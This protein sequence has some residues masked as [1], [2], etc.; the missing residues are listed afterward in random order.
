MTRLR[1]PSLLKGRLLLALALVVLGMNAFIP[2]GYMVAPSSSHFL[3]VTLCP[4]TNP[5]ARSA[6][7]AEGH[8][9]SAD[10]GPNH[11]AMGHHASTSDDHA[12]ASGRADVDCAFSALAF[13]GNIPEQPRPDAISLERAQA[14]S[15]PLKL[16]AVSPGRHLRPPLRGPPL[17]G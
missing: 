17:H 12:P 13:A 4:E 10:A 11:A 9:Q 7:A 15:A 14:L 3:A 16:F 6:M 2:A 8:S 5:L 1:N